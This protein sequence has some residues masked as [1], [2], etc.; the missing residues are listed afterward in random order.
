MSDLEQ[1]N[2]G[3]FIHGIDIKE[4]ID[5]T[6]MSEDNATVLQ[7]PFVRFSLNDFR[8][9]VKIHKDFELKWYVI[10]SDTS[11][12]SKYHY[13]LYYVKLSELKSISPGI[14][15]QKH[16]FIIIDYDTILDD[17][18]EINQTLDEI[19]ND[20]HT[21]CPINVL[22]I[23]LNEYH[24]LNKL[25][26]DGTSD[27]SGV[28]F[29]F[30]ST[31]DLKTL[32]SK[33][34]SSESKSADIKKDLRRHLKTLDIN[35]EIKQTG[36]LD[37][38]STLN[39]HF[40]LHTQKKIIY[41][42]Y[43]TKWKQISITSDYHTIE[44]V[45][46]LIKKTYDITYFKPE[47]YDELI[48]QVDKIFA[49]KIKAYCEKYGNCLVFLSKPEST[50]QIKPES[51]PPIKPESTSQIKSPHPPSAIF[52]DVIDPYTFHQNLMLFHGIAI[53]FNIPSIRAY[54]DG[55]IEKVNKKIVNY[56][57]R[58]I[59]KITN[60]DNIMAFL[61]IVDYHDKTNLNASFQKIFSNPKVISDNVTHN[62]IW[63]KF[64]D[65]CTRMSIPHESIL[66]LLTEVVMVKINHHAGNSTQNLYLNC[67]QVFLLKNL[68]RHF[69]FTKLLMYVQHVIRYAGKNMSD[70]IKNLTF[71]DYSEL[72]ILEQK[73][74]T[75]SAVSEDELS[76]RVDVDKVHVI[77]SFGSKFKKN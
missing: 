4:S 51:T 23:R 43:L 65:K 42:N 58:D 48:D 18:E 77:E 70:L 75:L 8:P 37:L 11:N 49:E 50:P 71:K 33:Y 68:S 14:S 5:V 73:L 15:P 7:H 56:H 54:L 52:I 30:L 16:L 26:A 31:T 69:V 55:E 40:K 29:S 72:L 19:I 32:H 36:I 27:G 21:S 34:C 28:D 3:I 59:E 2:V 53:S 13:I 12:D 46:E 10:P 20:G 6:S 66:Q 41:Q 9:N 67:L 57:T 17:E 47:I 38:L 22:T 74:L 35:S 39:P 76:Q 60:L 45:C 25:R 63:C 44:T 24:I 61:E 64:I 62:E 1:I